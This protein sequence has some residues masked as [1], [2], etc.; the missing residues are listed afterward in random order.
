MS[1][2][3]RNI[4]YYEKV[5]NE[6]GET[7]Y[8]LRDSIP[9]YEM[10]NECGAGDISNPKDVHQTVAMVCNR[11]FQTYDGIKYFIILFQIDKYEGYFRF[12]KWYPMNKGYNEELIKLLLDVK[13]VHRRPHFKPK[14]IEMDVDFDNVEDYEYSIYYQRDLRENS[15]NIV[16]IEP[17]EESYSQTGACADCS[18]LFCED[19][20]SLLEEEDVDERKDVQFTDFL[21]F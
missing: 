9:S 2:E 14:N 20:L 6:I 11:R 1:K 10:I 12:E 15:Y 17:Q 18:E 8:G 5:R 13:A 16:A 21:S 19:N 4:V 3:I 7:Y